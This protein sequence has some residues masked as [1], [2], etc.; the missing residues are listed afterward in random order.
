MSAHYPVLSP[1]PSRV[2]S[3]FGMT[4]IDDA[5]EATARTTLGAAAASDLGSYL[6]L[7][8]GVMTGLMKFGGATSSFP[9]MKNN[10]AVLESRLADDSGL[11]GF[12]ADK[13]W[14]KNASNYEAHLSYAQEVLVGDGTYQLLSFDSESNAGY[15]NAF[16][17][18]KAG[19]LHAVFSASG[20]ETR[21]T[22]QGGKPIVF[23]QNTGTSLMD[24]LTIRADGTVQ[25]GGANT[26]GAWIYSHTTPTHGFDVL[27]SKTHDIYHAFTDSSNYQGGRVTA[28][29]SSVTF[30]AI[31]AGT[32]ADNIDVVL[33][34]AG[35]GLVQFGTHS[36]VGAETVTGYI[37][38]KDSG[39]TERKLA[40]IS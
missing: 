26:G 34:P 7:A 8:G 40:V 24:M 36:A 39:G 25:L 23:R 38:I 14:F 27:A 20:S 4:L 12:R 28:G 19:V 21:I 35:T 30:G 2:A 18:K 33:A 13:F 32:G 17:L 37:T 11:A 1:S 3:A 9:A 16:G 31:T 10:G 29:A 5:D 22:G 15:G 6:P